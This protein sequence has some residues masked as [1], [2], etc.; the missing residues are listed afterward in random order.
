[1]AT[2]STI[3][4]W[5]NNLPFVARWISWN[6]MWL[7]QW[8]ATAEPAFFFLEKANRCSP[9]RFWSVRL[10]WSMLIALVCTHEENFNLIHFIKWFF[11]QLL[12]WLLVRRREWLLAN[13]F[14]DVYYE[15]PWKDI[16][17]T[18]GN[19][20]FSKSSPMYKWICIK[21]LILRKFFVK[22]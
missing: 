4:S 18:L 21:I 1:M 19:Y 9:I 16:W 8:S 14:S 10:V 3:S 22:C 7:K 6:S 2:V 17:L 12:V 20:Q 13:D 11:V 15:E 5:F